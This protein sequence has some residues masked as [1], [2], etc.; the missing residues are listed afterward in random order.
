MDRLPDI[1]D[2]YKPY[3]DQQLKSLLAGRNLSFYDMIRYHLGWADSRGRSINAGS[4]KYLR[5]TLCLLGCESTGSG[6]ERALP[7][8]AAIELVHNYSLVHDDIQD[9][10]RVRRHRPTVWSIWGKPQAINAGSAMRMIAGL[11]LQELGPLGVSAEKQV[12]AAAIMDSACLEMIEGQYLDIGF[13]AAADIGLGQYMDMIEK[14]TSALIRAALMMGACLNIGPKE[15]E[16][17]SSLG[18]NLGLAF[19][20]RDDMLGIWGNDK[21]TGKPNG[22]DIRKKKKSF[23]VVY[24]LE[25]APTGLREKFLEI[26]GRKKISA[27]DVGQVIGYLEEAGAREYSQREADHFYQKTL[28]AIQDLPLKPAAR[29]DFT[30]ISEFLVK[31][32]F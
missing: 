21:K 30:R 1:F 23:P 5:A 26:Y 31:R 12:D 15:L 25:N 4:G 6:F 18:T 16:F 3:I 19:Q 2:K 10:D 29:R 11:S 22:S 14:K 13:E 17:F 32:E 7:L 9:N 27:G 24:L 8:A 28:E 20:I